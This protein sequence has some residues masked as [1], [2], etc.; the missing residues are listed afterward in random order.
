MAAGG[1]ED[2]NRKILTFSPVE[3]SNEFNGYPHDYYIRFLNHDSV[4]PQLLF[5]IFIISN[6]LKGGE[7]CPAESLDIRKT[8]EGRLFGLINGT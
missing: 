5:S 8:A 6:L 3:N 4:S 2:V 1:K 7:F